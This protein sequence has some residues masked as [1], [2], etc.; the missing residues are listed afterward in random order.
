MFGR[1]TIRLGIGPHSSLFYFHI[2]ASGV[3]LGGRLAHRLDLNLAEASIK[4][5]V[6]LNS[7]STR[8]A[9]YPTHRACRLLDVRKQVLCI[10][11]L[12]VTVSAVFGFI[13]YVCVA[14]KYVSLS[15]TKSVSVPWKY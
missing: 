3:L 11:V 13:F 9:K 4:W 15:R 12:N 14:I 10:T 5:C 1:A 8:P 2:V 6:E 7:G